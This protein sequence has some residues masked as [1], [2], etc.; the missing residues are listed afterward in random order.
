M[1]ILYDATPLLVRSA[2][3]KNY[4]HSLLVRLLARIRPHR[5]ELFPFL[6]NVGRNRN[7]GS[8]YPRS[9]TA[10]RLAALLADN[11][12]RLPVGAW[13]ARSADVFHVTHHLM[14]PPAGVKLTS[15]VHD[16]TPLLMPELHTASNVR[17]FRSF[18]E[19]V[20]P[21]LAGIIVPSE[22]VRRDLAE[23]LKVRDDRI[24]VIPHGVDEDFFPMGGQEPKRRAYDLP[25]QYVLFLGSLEPRKNLPAA[26]EAWR[27]L[28]E[29]LRRQYP[30]VVAGASGWKNAALKSELARA[31]AEGV[32]V[33]GYVE[34]HA[35]P[36]VYGSAAVFVFPS[37]Y[38]GF[39]MPLLEAMAAGAPVV[40]SNTS[41][42]PEVAG[43]AGLLVDPKSPAEL[44]RAIERV[45]T[46]RAL[47]ATLVEKGR[48]R[49]REFTW[50]RTADATRAFFE[51]VSA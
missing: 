49:A 4:H 41:S 5:L 9:G 37:L 27:L 6:H 47:A 13:A 18:A 26:L 31:K 29:E 3:V 25:D 2:G 16:V 12:L 1:K 38:E 40:T 48:A 19:R 50:D 35:L 28:P 24:T 8:N 33:I 45:L 32:R 22:S 46:D 23:R 42:L 44:A 10:W 21:R 15:F 30:M 43:D 51:K 20:L 39:G 34:P 36:L 11:Y 7:E 14:H 17:Y